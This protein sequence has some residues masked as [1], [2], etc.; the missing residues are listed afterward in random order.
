MNFRSPQ[1]LWETALGSLQIQ[2]SPANY[3]TWLKNTIGLSFESGLFVVGVPHAFGAEWLQRRLHS[4]IRRTLIDITGQDLEVE[5][6]VLSSQPSARPTVA[7]PPLGQP[8]PAVAAP[9]RLNP[10]YTFDTF[11]VG[12]G[13]RLAYVAAKE[14]AENPGKGY[15]PLFIY[16]SPGLGKTHLLH[17]IGHTSQGQKLRHA[18]LSAESFTNE[19]IHA[20]LERQITDFHRRYRELDILLV[21]DLNFL[22][23][24]QKTEEMFF[25]TFN[26]LHNAGHQIVVTCDCQPR[27]LTLI[28]ERLRSRLAWGLVT[29][30]EPPDQDTRMAILEAKARQMGP[31][32]SREV[33]EL[34]CQ[35]AGP[36]VRDLE[37]CLN[38]VSA[39]A[40]VMGVPLTP[41][42]ARCILQES[43]DTPQAPSVIT[44]EEILA[45]VAEHFKLAV[46]ALIG[47]ERNLLL[48]Q[49]RLV[50][51]LLLR[52]EGHYPLTEIGRLLGNRDHSTIIHGYKKVSQDINGDGQLLQIVLTIKENLHAVRLGNRLHPV[53]RLKALN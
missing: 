19:Y 6:R 22:S 49:A 16:S 53:P 45:L 5:F 28:K 17:A 39:M 18:Y 24:K 40:R 25:H 7:P 36:T 4:L 26:E 50:A 32:I 9:G 34:I 10:R 38:R 29:S 47:R 31:G 8:T 21:D 52:E 2:V 44:P 12:N 30:I 13:N 1:L 51:I 43:P 41:E 14:A 46:A 11:V 37:G 20:V 33:L 27:A 42:V 23:G 48:A 35:R 3:I 15:N